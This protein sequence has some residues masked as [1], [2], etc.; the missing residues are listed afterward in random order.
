MWE[1]LD[2]SDNDWERLISKQKGTTY[3]HSVPWAL[4]SQDL[5]WI[6][7]RWQYLEN[8]KPVSFLQGGVKIYFGKIGI[9]WYPDWIIGDTRKTNNL[10]EVIRTTLGLKYAYMR[11]RSTEIYAEK[12][13]KILLR[14]GWSRPNNSFGTAL[15]M[16]LDLAKPIEE[17]HSSF[18]KKWR[19]SLRKS[20]DLSFRIQEIRSVTEI[21]K[22]YEEL[23]GLKSLKKQQ[24]YGLQ[25]IS[26][27]VRCFGINII[28]LGAVDHDGNLLAIRGSII[29]DKDAIDIFA[30]TGKLGR[31][32]NVSHALFFDLV[33]HCKKLGCN[34]YDLGG[35]DPLNNP[36]VYNFKKGTGANKI[37]QLGEFEWSNNLILKLAVNFLSKYR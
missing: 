21:S 35:I 25:K 31:K 16:Q 15:T 36:G 24:V 10:G 26:S 28:T 32:M 11:F 37:S 1:L 20:N 8:G 22:L 19:K 18:G 6:V 29:R 7:R 27:L 17:I 4:H 30:A 34:T 13:Q 12:K 14:N 23:K 9:F 2:C 3:L 33:K 5:G